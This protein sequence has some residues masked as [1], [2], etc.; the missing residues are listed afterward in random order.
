[1]L[2]RR[3]C[4]LGPLGQLLFGTI[5]CERLYGNYL[6]FELDTDTSG[7]QVLRNSLDLSWDYLETKRINRAEIKYF[8]AEIDNLTPDSE[9]FDSEFT[10]F[11]QETCFSICYLLESILSVKSDKIAQIASFSIDSVDLYVQEIENMDP[12]DL[13]LEFKI[14]RHPFMQ[15]ELKVQSQVYDLIASTDE[16]N[17]SLIR[18]LKGQWRALK[19]SNINLP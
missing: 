11:A 16:L 14:L 9:G 2:A 15:R 19:K 13:E 8:V 7:S 18:S 5:C 3:L 6:A 1:M 4:R 17:Q 10:S 12:G